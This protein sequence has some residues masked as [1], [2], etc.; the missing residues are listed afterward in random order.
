MDSYFIPPGGKY[1]RCFDFMMAIMKTLAIL[2]NEGE[3]QVRGERK[4]K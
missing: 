2:F 1:E 4:S 3:I